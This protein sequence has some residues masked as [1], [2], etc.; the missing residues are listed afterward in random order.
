MNVSM[1]GAQFIVKNFLGEKIPRV[2]HIKEG[3][4][5]TISGT[6][7]VVE[8]INKEIAGQVSADIEQLCRITNRD[9]RIFQ[10]GIYI[11][12]KAKKEI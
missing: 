12:Q 10:D 7:V 8:S 2:L 6:E 11:T 9:R 4:K 1:S 3:A 5:V